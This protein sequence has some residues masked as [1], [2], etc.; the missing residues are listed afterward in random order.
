MK[1]TMIV[2]LCLISLLVTGCGV[3]KLENGEEVVATVGGKNITANDLYNNIKDAYGRNVLI[4]MIDKII[5]EKKYKTTDTMTKTVNSQLS[6]YKEQLG[7]QFIP[8]IKNQLG[9]NSEEEFKNLL[10]LDYKRTEATKDYIKTLITDAEINDYYEDETVGNIKASHIL[11]KPEVTDSMTDD[12]KEAKEKEAEDLAKEIINKLNN[13]EKFADLAKKHSDDGSASNG[14]DL[15]WFNKGAMVK[16][17]EDAAFALKKDEYSKTPV[18]SEFGYHIIL[19]TDEKEKPKLEDVKDDIID[20]L[21]EER[22]SVQDNVLGFEAM[23]KLRKDNKLDI[24]DS[25]LKRQYD[26]YMNELVK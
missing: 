5:L 1:K 21:V 24:Q 6:Y 12:E 9:V 10:Y 26:S 14:G 4:D 22:L 11:I 20:T 15:G 2:S 13:G 23:I 8:Y 16:A 3:A 18:K 19:K 7:D 17:F 25:E